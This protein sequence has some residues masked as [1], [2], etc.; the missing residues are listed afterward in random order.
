MKKIG[1]S[2]IVI[3]F[4]VGFTTACDKNTNGNNTPKA[5]MIHEH[6]TRVG[7]VQGNGQANLSYEIYYTG[8]V[9]NKIESTEEI[10][11]TSS[12]LLDQYEQA[13]KGIATHYEGIKNYKVT[14]K[15]TSNSVTN[16]IWINY[17]KVD[18]EQLLA[19]EG[20]EDN[21]FENK[22]AKIAKWKELTKK[23]GMTCEAAS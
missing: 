21:I 22:V 10:I 4:L 23:V 13:F 7:H 2:I 11:S 8:E 16:H 14:I 17:D 18:A 15:R 19:I 1:I 6:C 20:E 12:D 9:L 5:K 3:L